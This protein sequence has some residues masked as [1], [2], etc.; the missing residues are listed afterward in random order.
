MEAVTGP[1]VLVGHSYGGSVITNAA[2]GNPNV[3]SLVYIAGFVPDR[4]ES[5]LDLSNKFPAA[6]W[7][8]LWSRSRSAA[9]WICG[10][11]RTCSRNSSPPTYP[12]MMRV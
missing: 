10:Y 7:A 2:R 6:R 11:A 12:L 4:G 3:R 1:I 8:P 5:A 9:P